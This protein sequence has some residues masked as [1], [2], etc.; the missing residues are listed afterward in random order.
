MAKKK[1]EFLRPGYYNCNYPAG[2]IVEVDEKFAEYV[3]GME[4]A[5]YASAEAKVTDP[6]PYV[7]TPRKTG[8][9]DALQTI[10]NALTGVVA[11]KPAAPVTPPSGKAA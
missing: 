11:S 3:V 2:S 10:A 4:D 7:M 9:E 6:I 5:R 8:A 1:I